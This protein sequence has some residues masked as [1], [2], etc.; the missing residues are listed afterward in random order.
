MFNSSAFWVHRKFQFFITYM[1]RAQIFNFEI[2]SSFNYQSL[3]QVLIWLYKEAAF[4]RH[5][6]IR[7]IQLSGHM[8]GNHLNYL[9]RKWLQDLRCLGKKGFIWWTKSWV[10]NPLLLS[11]L[12]I[13]ESLFLFSSRSPIATQMGKFPSSTIRIEA[14]DMVESGWTLKF[15]YKTVRN[16]GIKQNLYSYDSNLYFIE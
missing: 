6:N 8:F 16:V 12:N 2:T 14:C 5:S 1:Y 13:S 7:N 3:K 15:K 4:I 10:Y 9:Y 11:Y